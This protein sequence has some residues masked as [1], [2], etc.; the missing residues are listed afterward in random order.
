MNHPILS[1]FEP[2]RAAHNLAL[3]LAK[4]DPHDRISPSSERFSTDLV[5]VYSDAVTAKMWEM[6][7][8][9][10]LKAVCGSGKWNGLVCQCSMCYLL[11]GHHVSP[12]MNIL[13]FLRGLFFNLWFAIPSRASCR[14]P[15]LKLTVNAHWTWF[16][17]T[18]WR[19]RRSFWKSNGMLYPRPEQPSIY[20][21]ITC[22]VRQI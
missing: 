18:T 21:E 1:T 7:S 14:V 16:R 6:L 22:T 11:P 19:S 20:R 17:R 5:N 2:V 10:T 13:V 4:E 8:G 15:G 12:N 9:R 3:E